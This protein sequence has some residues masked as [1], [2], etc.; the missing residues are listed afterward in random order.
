MAGVVEQLE[1]RFNEAAKRR[2]PRRGRRQP[3]L[4]FFLQVHMATG[5]VHTNS[6]ERFNRKSR[7]CTDVAGISL[8][9]PAIV[10][11]VDALG[12]SSRTTSGL[13]PAA[14]CPPTP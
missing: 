11:L 8:N 7:R 3:G 12:W 4:Y 14:R 6:Q 5:V 1:K 10:R 2:R 13:S 9:R